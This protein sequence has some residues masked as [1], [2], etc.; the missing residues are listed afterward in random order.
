M[1]N[2]MLYKLVP[3]TEAKENQDGTYT[4]VNILNTKYPGGTNQVRVETIILRGKAFKVIAE[5]I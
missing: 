4:T 1:R 3:I 5:A 2:E